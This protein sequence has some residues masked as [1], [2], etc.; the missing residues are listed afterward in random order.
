MDSIAEKIIADDEQALKIRKGQEKGVPEGKQLT[1]FKHWRKVVSDYAQRKREEFFKQLILDGMEEKKAQAESHKPLS[2]LTVACYMADLLHV[3]RIESDEGEKPV[4]F[5]NPDEG[6]YKHDLEF[7]K[8]FIS[9]L[10][11]RHNEKKAYDCLYALKRQAPYR[12]VEENDQYIMVGNGIYNRKIRQ[13]E[14]F[15]WERIFTSKV[16]TA[17]KAEATSP[18]IKGWEFES[19]LKDLF[20]G[21]EE[22]YQLTLQL[23]NAAIRGRSL[24]KMFWFVGTGG[25]GKGTLQEL[26]TNLIGRENVAS[27]KITD[28]D[29]H[30]R[31]TLSQAIGKRAIIGDDVQA[32]AILRDTSK[33]FSLVSGDMVSVERKK[34]DAYSTYL[35]TVVIQSTN[36]LPRMVGDSNAIKRRMVILPFRNSF[37]GKP[38]RAIKEDYLKRPKVLEYVLKLIIDLDY[39]DFIQ[40]K[41]SAEQME[42]YQRGIDPVLTFI[43]ELFGNAISV[44]L[45]NDFVW[46]YFSNF[47]EYNGHEHNY[48]LQTLNTRLKENLPEEW[49]KT[50]HPVT[51]PAGADFPKGFYPKEDTAG[52]MNRTYRPPKAKT[53][54]GYRKKNR[55]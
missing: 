27:I 55:K 43:E 6:L 48:N 42:E 12:Q 23:L 38:N 49:E 50:R 4:Y 52:Y 9:V 7:L 1:T 17:Y 31:F 39:K 51:V 19:W 35:K 41:L 37:T 26:F 44:F 40:P 5:Y 13:L 28:L 21:D 16:K 46:W 47:A 2:P 24:D 15:T 18:I 20:A 22:L 3:C 45:P 33:L 36:G 8:D 10:E 29:I 25:T 14:P 11:P 34:K 32:G 53:S 54:R 30:N